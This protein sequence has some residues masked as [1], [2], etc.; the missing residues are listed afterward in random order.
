MTY[1]G[2]I[3]R[4][5]TCSKHFVGF[6]YIFLQNVLFFNILQTHTGPI[7]SLPAVEGALPASQYASLLSEPPAPP[8]PPP[9]ALKPLVG[10]FETW[11]VGCP[12]AAICLLGLR[13]LRTSLQWLGEATRPAHG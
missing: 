12:D 5:P 11:L 10:K 3:E 7:C 8:L 6:L 13:A 2:F 4:S 9:E 1:F